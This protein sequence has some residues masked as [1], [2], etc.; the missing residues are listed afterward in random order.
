MSPL[1]RHIALL[2]LVVAPSLIH[3]AG[4]PH[5]TVYFYNTWEQLLNLE[6]VSMLQD[7]YVDAQ[8]PYQLFFEIEDEKWNDVIEHDFMAASMGDSI[9]LVN[10]NYLKLCFEGDIQSLVGYVPLFFNEKV[11]YI[12]YGGYP[13]RNPYWEHGYYNGYNRNRMHHDI[14]WHYYYIDFEHRKVLKVN[15]SVLSDLLKDYH[16]LLMR[17]EGMNDY[18]KREIIEDYFLKYID[19]AAQDVMHPNIVDVVEDAKWNEQ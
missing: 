16:D 18:K 14:V 12:C 17:Y 19:R 10:S 6:P 8:S 4:E 13:Y 2:L 15:H 9:W 11:A 1:T 7:P 3:A 5:D